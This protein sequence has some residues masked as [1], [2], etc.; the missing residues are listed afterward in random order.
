MYFILSK[1]QPYFNFLSYTRGICIFL[2]FVPFDIDWRPTAQELPYF[3]QLFATALGD[4]N[5]TVN[6]NGTTELGGAAAVQFFMKSKL[7]K[8]LLKQIW[9]ASNL[10]NGPSLNKREFCIAMRLVAMIQSN[11][12]LPVTR[13]SFLATMNQSLPLPKF[14]GIQVPSTVV[15]SSV[16]TTVLPTVPSINTNSGVSY[17]ISPTDQA[18][19]D[20]IFASQDTDRDGF[21]DANTAVE[22]FTKSGL[23]KTILKLI[24]TL[25]DIDT[26]K[27]LDHDEFSI[28]MHLVVGA[29]KRGMTV[30]PTLPT[31]LIPSSK[32]QYF[33]NTVN[34]VPTVVT[35]TVNN[36]ARRQSFGMM[37][38]VTTPVNPPPAPLRVD[39]AFSNMEIPSI[40]SIPPPTLTTPPV[41]PVVVPAPVPVPAPAPVPVAPV[42]PVVTLSNTPSLPPRR[43][44]FAP[45]TVPTPAPVPVPIPAVVPVPTVPTPLS[46][47]TNISSSS[48]NSAASIPSS[49]SVQPLLSTA[50]E[51]EDAMRS[52]LRKENS[53]L[54]MRN[55]WL[56]DA[57]N[58]LK[59][60]E[61]ERAIFHKQIETVRNLITT[62]ESEYATTINRIQILRAEIQKARSTEATLSSTL[63]DKRRTTAE[64][65][66]VLTSLATTLV[67][68]TGKTD[69]LEK[70]IRTLLE[71][72][73]GNELAAL[74]ATSTA[75]TLSTVADSHAASANVNEAE[76]QALRTA[77]QEIEKRIYALQ[78]E[79]NDVQNRV[80][81]STSKLAESKQ[82]LKIAEQ[83]VVVERERHET[84]ISNKIAAK[85]AHIDALASLHTAETELTNAHLTQSN[86]TPAIPTNRTTTHPPAPVTVTV[87]APPSLPPKRTVE[88]VPAPVPVPVTAPA[89]A[90]VSSAFDDDFTFNAS[91]SAAEVT[92][93]SSTTVPSISNSASFA[94]D[95]AFGGDSSV[96][97]PAPAVSTNSLDSDDT[98]GGNDFASA[99]V[100]EP[101]HLPVSHQSTSNN[102][103]LDDSFGF[104]LPSSSGANAVPTSNE[105]VDGFDSPSFDQPATIS[106]NT[107][108]KVPE[109]DDDAFN[110]A[111]TPAPA[112]AV[113]NPKVNSTTTNTVDDFGSF[114]DFGTDAFGSS[115]SNGSTSSQ[116][117]QSSSVGFDDDFAS[118]FNAAPAPVSVPSSNKPSTATNQPPSQNFTWDF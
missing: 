77:V 2:L 103:N 6:G 25:S 12:T 101:E 65:K 63:A 71:T 95:F 52:H 7:D 55:E 106:T 43:G 31:E 32:Q 93:F 80:I 67:T 86:S 24:W 20:T 17:A 68:M 28:A 111:S 75:S 66:G 83:R 118:A 9:A 46:T 38:P 42:I 21:I 19:Y 110:F 100:S 72:V 41:V 76:I 62:E 49:V 85:E 57:L 4:A 79:K 82:S 47:N 11:S 15:P 44:S 58:E 96:P 33:N 74:Q 105:V 112:P 1:P 91:P 54:E 109:D 18:K 16:S 51:L 94:D 8:P 97:A 70:E 69:T 45:S 60:L 40:V 84:S 30:P 35:N 78:Q 117:G 39:D 3:E 10:R 98:F 87:T 116:H 88:A 50:T 36:A 81:S 107:T 102:T 37:A 53:A 115:N 104:S 23:D 89:P 92:S 113:T 99:N 13:D 26:D 108:S 22:L 48:I 14:E 34:T 29:S 56:S 73:L 59:R 27:R 90:P 64:S 5:N 114:G 61:G